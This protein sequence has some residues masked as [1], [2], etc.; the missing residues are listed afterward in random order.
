M[1]GNRGKAK[2]EE[3]ADEYLS[4][5]ELETLHESH[6]SIFAQI[7]LRSEALKRE[8][9]KA[10]CGRAHKAM[11]K[12]WADLKRYKFSISFLRTFGG[13]LAEL[14]K[15]ASQIEDKRL[16]YGIL[17][18]CRNMVE[19]ARMLGNIARRDV[20]DEERDRLNGQNPRSTSS[21]KTVS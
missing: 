4:L 7:S 19:D 9:D 13:G 11:Q 6:D 21:P 5:A 15:L 2:I 20:I 1:T 17:F 14:D 12:I 16:R 3:L 10:V 8:L 18:F